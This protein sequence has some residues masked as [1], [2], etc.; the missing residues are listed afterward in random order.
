LFRLQRRL[1]GLSVSTL[2]NLAVLLAGS[3]RRELRDDW[4]AHLA[5]ES[6]HAPITWRR[7]REAFGFVASAVRFRLADAADVA[8]RPADV[9]LGFVPCPTCSCGARSLWCSSPSCITT[10]GSGSSPASRT[11]PRW[12]PDVRRPTRHLRG[13][14]G[15]GR[16][17]LPMTAGEIRAAGRTAVTPARRLAIALAAVHAARPQV[18]PPTHPGRHR[19][20][21]PAHHPRRS[22]AAPRRAHPRRPAGLARIPG[23]PPGRIPPAGTSWSRASAPWAPDRSHPTT[24][25]STSCAASAANASG[26]TASCRNPW[27]PAPILSTS[28]WFSASTT[29]TRWPTPTPPATFSAVQPNR[30]C[31]ATRNKLES[32][33]GTGS[34]RP[35]GMPTGAFAGP[36]AASG[37][38]PGDTSAAAR[39]YTSSRPEPLPPGGPQPSS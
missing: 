23:V 24:P 25:A 1:R 2:T 8:W 22:P 17:V 28:L 4:Y 3:R 13:G 33:P 37:P 14:R 19:P 30:H 7:D 11:R 29:P 21:R 15:A 16:T 31:H 20:A 34:Y 18:H 6:G 36:P 12:V 5:G 9:V 32:T 27:P 26:A 38:W 39:A 10:A 35:I